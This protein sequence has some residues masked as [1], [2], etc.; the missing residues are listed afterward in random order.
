MRKSFQIVGLGVLLTLA[1]ASCADGAG[2]SWS[3]SRTGNVDANRKFQPTNPAQVVV[4]PAQEK[5]ARPFAVIGK[6]EVTVNKTTAFHPS[7]TVEAVTER[8]KADAAQLGADAI[9][10]VVIGNT[11]VGALTWGSRNGNAVAI[12]YLN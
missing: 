2:G 8:L 6:V 5:P 4:L 10:D 9:M 3:Y 11:H 1:L 7:P 12:K